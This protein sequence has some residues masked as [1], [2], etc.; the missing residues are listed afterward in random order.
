MRCGAPAVP[1]WGEHTCPVGAVPARRCNS[2]A[3][4]GAVMSLASMKASSAGMNLRML[5]VPRYTGTVPANN[6]SKA[7]SE[8]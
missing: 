6:A 1:Y 7:F 3:S 5:L 4:A 8:T 2:A